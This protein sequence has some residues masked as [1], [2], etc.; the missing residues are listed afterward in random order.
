MNNLNVYKKYSNTNSG[1]AIIKC[2]ASLKVFT[3]SSRNDSS[4]KRH[5]AKFIIEMNIQFL[6]KLRDFRKAEFPEISHW[7]RLNIAEKF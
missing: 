1:L 4:S 2:N 7:V 5:T 6:E 3:S